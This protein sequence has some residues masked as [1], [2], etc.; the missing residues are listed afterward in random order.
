MN[1]ILDTVA[2]FANLDYAAISEFVVRG[3][4][5]TFTVYGDLMKEYN[6]Y[7]AGEHPDYFRGGYQLGK[8]AKQFL[9]YN[10][11]N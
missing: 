1:E 2:S 4:V 5:S 6:A 10:I 9:D 7:I 8:L 3:G 11:N